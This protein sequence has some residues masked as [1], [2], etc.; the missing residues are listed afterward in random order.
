[1]DLLDEALLASKC[2]VMS[3]REDLNELPSNFKVVV[4]GDPHR[5]YAV[6][7]Q[8][9]SATSKIFFKLYL[10]LEAGKDV[11]EELAR[12]ESDVSGHFSVHL[13]D[14]SVLQ[15]GSEHDTVY[16]LKQKIAS[17]YGIASER[18]DLYTCAEQVKKCETSSGKF[19]GMDED[20]RLV[21]SY[22]HCSSI[23]LV[24]RDNWMKTDLK[25]KVATLT[26]PIPCSFT[27]FERVLD[28]MYSWHIQ[29]APFQNQAND[30]N[31]R[32]A[33]CM[34]FLATRLRIERL[35]EQLTAQLQQNISPLEAPALIAPAAALGLNKVREHAEQRAAAALALAPPGV[36]DGLPLSSFENVLRAASDVSAPARAAA[37][38]SFLAAR[39]AAGRLEEAS[40]R[41]L[42]GLLPAAPCPGGAT[43][44][45]PTAEVAAGGAAG[46]GEGGESGGRCGG[47]AGG[48]G[49]GGAVDGEVMSAAGALVLLRGALRFGDAGLGGVCLAR[50]AARFEELQPA[51]LAALPIPTVA[52]LLSRCGPPPPHPAPR[53]TARRAPGGAVLRLCCQSLSPPRLLTSSTSGAHLLDCCA[54]PSSDDLAE[55][56]QY[57]TSI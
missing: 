23:S 4:N 28:F 49:E 31:P 32:S 5:E 56:D 52:E 54:A 57:L 16:Q 29:G 2:P 12:V 6:H 37:V 55:C 48:G 42:V 1:M 19:E 24:I 20:W 38:T 17:F 18:L 14:R 11:D 51:M 41:R 47:W 46:A 43:G 27:E 25:D 8:V 44:T 30:P 33:L 26:L 53:A 40:F 9:L 15:I 10:I 39:D 50:L 21:S 13:Q 34:L 36:F 35:A 7:L 22:T 45:G 3:W